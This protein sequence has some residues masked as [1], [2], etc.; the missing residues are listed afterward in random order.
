MAARGLVGAGAR[1]VL[2]GP[3]AGGRPVRGE[4]VLRPVLH[5]ALGAGSLGHGLAG[6]RREARRR[7]GP[8][9]RG[10]QT[11]R[12]VDAAR[13]PADPRHAVPDTDPVEHRLP[14]ARRDGLPAARLRRHAAA[15]AAGAGAAVRPAR[16]A[17]RLDRRGRAGPP[18][19]RLRPRAQGARARGRRARPAGIHDRQPDVPRLAAGQDRDLPGQGR[20]RLGPRPAP[21]RR[22]ARRVD[23]RRAVPGRHLLVP[24]RRA[25]TVGLRPLHRRLRAARADA[26]QPRGHRAGR[27]RRGRAGLPPGEPARRAE[28]DPFPGHA[29]HGGRGPRRL[30]LP[31]PGPRGVRGMSARGDGRAVAGAA[32]RARLDGV[33]SRSGRRAAL[34]RGAHGSWRCGA[35]ARPP[36]AWSPARRTTC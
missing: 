11:G 8:R 21:G 14:A 18:P 35:S 10:G 12:R 32:G 31:R 9:A 24:A 22:V 20:A 27:V 23:D 30:H 34:A 25:G 13:R 36:A 26:G 15:E 28:V 3:G 29:G 4:P 7:R 17:A 2:G 6:R 5:A 19:G 33:A 16:H 1:G